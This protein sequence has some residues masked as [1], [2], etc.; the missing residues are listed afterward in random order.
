MAYR[1]LVVDD[2]AVVRS[3]VRDVLESS[4]MTVEGAASGPEAL[5]CMTREVCDVLL[6]DLIMPEMSGLQLLSRTLH[7]F[8]DTIP[9]VFTA[10]ATLDT[11]RQA[12]REGA[13]DY[14]LKP[15]DVAELR[16]AVLRALERRRLLHENTRLRE[17]TGLFEV[18][19]AIGSTV[20]RDELLRLILRFALVQTGATRGSLM[21]LDE[22]G[23]H[24]KIVASVGLP[25][26]V[27]DQTWV[28][29]GQGIAGQVVESG[30][31]VL[32]R[33]IDQHDQYKRVSRNYGDK[34]FMSVPLECEGPIVALPMKTA[35]SVI[36][37]LN[38]H[39]KSDGNP[40]TE[41]ELKLLRILAGQA[42]ICIENSRLVTDL[43]ST[44]LSAFSTMSRLLEA[45]DPHTQGH[46]ER[47]T[48]LCQQLGQEL[49]SEPDQ[50]H[51]L[52]LAA[53]LHDIGKIG[54]HESI[55]NKPGKLT[56]EEWM[57]IRQHPVIGDRVLEPIHFLNAARPLVRGHHERLDGKGYP[58]GL[59]G[60]QLSVGHR[61]I[62]V[63]DAFD[64]MSSDR[65]YRPALSPEQI[66]HELQRNAGSQFD[67]TIAKRMVEL[68]HAGVPTF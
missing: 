47:V 21:L 66:E 2:E 20:G 32:V 13:Y 36:G 51:A 40:F 31:P 18:T 68:M 19:E 4:Q 30:R 35:R 14:I 23:R 8:P 28:P 59:Q 1:V 10:Y 12:I 45:K 48:A 50:L 52:M 27:V 39:R 46:T 38:V 16:S 37:V 25:R 58:D 7:D 55:L 61:I 65:A 54:V 9:I 53:R 6:T 44:Y 56:E 5:A 11:A 41:S 3:L 62:I 67:S 22:D 63:A 42:A 60:E 34:S 26:H 49:L 33:D 15:F 29:V 64:A 43:E 24:L 17:L 57:I